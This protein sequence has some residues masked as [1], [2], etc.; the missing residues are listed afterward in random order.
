MGGIPRTLWSSRIAGPRGILGL[1]GH[2]Y[3]KHLSSLWQ[4]TNKNIHAPQRKRLAQRKLK[5]AQL[6]NSSGSQLKVGSPRGQHRGC[7]HP[8]HTDSSLGSLS[9]PLR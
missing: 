2:F 7:T 9:I 4:A 6:N 1:C 5:H 3:R 8:L